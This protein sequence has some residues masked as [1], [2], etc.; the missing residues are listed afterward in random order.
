MVKQEF[1]GVDDGPHDVLK[2]LI[3]VALSGRL[4]V[5]RIG[6][7]FFGPWFAGKCLQ[8]NLPDFCNEVQFWIS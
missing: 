6:F 5:V 3:F 7:D 4:D 1:F 8:V 2:R